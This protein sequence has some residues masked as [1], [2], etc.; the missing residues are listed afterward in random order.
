MNVWSKDASLLHGVKK[1][2]R[3]RRTVELDHVVSAQNPQLFLEHLARSQCH[4]TE[5]S[6]VPLRR[7][8]QMRTAQGGCWLE[9]APGVDRQGFYYCSRAD[10]GS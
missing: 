4:R 7:L 8:H 3:S 6:P 1:Q 5:P 9:R 10:L 2:Q